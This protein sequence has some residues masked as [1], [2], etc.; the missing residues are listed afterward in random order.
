VPLRSVENAAR[1]LKYYQRLQENLANNLANAPTDGFKGDLMF[2]QLV[3]DSLAPTPLQ[4]LDLSQGS[5]RETGGL[6]DFALEGQG[7]LVVQTEAGE[8]LVRGGA[9]HLDPA[10]MLVDG[11]G[12]PVLGDDGPIVVP[13]DSGESFEVQADGGILV[14]GARIGVL[15]IENVTDPANLEKEGLGRYVATG[16]TQAVNPAETR[17]RQGAIEESNVDTINGMIDLITI[18]REFQANM[19]ALKALDGQLENVTTNI[20]RPI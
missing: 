8:R 13:G 19:T 4:A 11:Q 16:P 2:G 18:Q 5:L 17:L 7:F 3:G 9:M 12:D 15:R 1:A 20:G 10:G 14:G 6:Y